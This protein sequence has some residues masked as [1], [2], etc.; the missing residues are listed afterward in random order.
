[1]LRRQIE[2]LYQR[3]QA[4]IGV[5]PDSD[6][7]EDCLTLQFLLSEKEVKGDKDTAPS[8]R[9][10]QV[11][12]WIAQLEN[13]TTNKVKPNVQTSTNDNKS[14]RP[15]KLKQSTSSAQL[16]KEANADFDDEKYVEAILK[17][18][19]FIRIYRDRHQRNGDNTKIADIQFNIGMAYIKLWNKLYTA[20][21]EKS[22]ACHECALR[23]LSNAKNLYVDSAAKAACL[24]NITSL[25]LY[26]DDRKV[27]IADDPMSSESSGIDTASTALVQLSNMTVEFDYKRDPSNEKKRVLDDAQYKKLLPPKKRFRPDKN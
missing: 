15:A 2:E 11:Q 24:E 10:R 7:K 18:Q 5:A 26:E 20:D 25:I 22:R 14:M 1:M 8:D 3:V 23:H 21:M 17:Y 4:Q 16:E 19:S 13:G 12:Q 9:M 27:P 6:V